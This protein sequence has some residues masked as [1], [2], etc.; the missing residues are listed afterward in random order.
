MDWL[1]ENWFWLT[2]LVLFVFMHAGHGH[3]GHG[4]HGHSTGDPGNDPPEGSHKN[5]HKGKEDLH[6]QH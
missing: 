1:R 5:H 4:G 6:D 3:G 2:V